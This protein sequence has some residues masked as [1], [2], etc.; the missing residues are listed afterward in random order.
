VRCLFHV[1]VADSSVPRKLKLSCGIF[2]HPQLFRARHFN[3]SLSENPILTLTLIHKHHP[4]IFVQAKNKFHK[5]HL[6]IKIRIK[7]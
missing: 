2:A 6:K 1:I 3:D 5:N 4:I 7:K